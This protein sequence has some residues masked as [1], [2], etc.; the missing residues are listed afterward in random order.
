ME[1]AL[2]EPAED[3]QKLIQTVDNENQN[4]SVKFRKAKSSAALK[5]E[6]EAH[7]RN[8]SREYLVKVFVFTYC[9]LIN[10]KYRFIRV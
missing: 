3:S 8:A 10:G 4:E 1:E 2:P 6:L 5:K 7:G 9:L